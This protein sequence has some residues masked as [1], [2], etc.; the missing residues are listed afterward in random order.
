MAG[1]ATE[2]TMK[3]GEVLFKQGDTGTEMFLIRSG[4]VKITRSA[5]GQEKTLAVLKEGDFFGEMAVIDGSPRSANAIAA[6]E[7]KLLTIDRE[8]FKAQLKSNPMIE[9]VLE[10]MARRLRDTNKMV[11]FLMIRDELRR[12]VSLLVNMANERGAQTPDGVIVDFPYDYNALG[13]MVGI[14][15]AKV[16]EIIRK[17]LE[18]KLVR[19]QDRKL[20]IPSLANIDEY[21]RFITLKEKFGA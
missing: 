1:Q 18:L 17:L 6:E 21:L 19:I 20:V 12:V 10:T 15:G 2:K 9:Y 7:A 8:A 14:D 3:P 13:D 4:K 16:E 11:E 5:G